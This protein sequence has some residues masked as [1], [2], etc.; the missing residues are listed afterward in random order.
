MRADS[1]LGRLILTLSRRSPAFRAGH[2]CRSS[3]A[4]ELRRH[5]AAFDRWHEDD[6]VRAH[7]LRDLFMRR[8]DELDPQ[9]SAR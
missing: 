3:I 7:A 5:A 8:A 6:V 1:F 9:D 2:D 4:A